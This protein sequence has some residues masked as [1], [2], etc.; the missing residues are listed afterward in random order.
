MILAMIVCD[1]RYNGHVTI[2]PFYNT[3]QIQLAFYYYKNCEQYDS[4]RKSVDANCKTFVEGLRNEGKGADEIKVEEEKYMGTNWRDCFR[5][6]SKEEWI[7]KYN[8][9]IQREVIQQYLAKKPEILQRKIIVFP[10]NFGESHW[11]TTFVFNPGNVLSRDQGSLRTCFFRYCSNV[12]AGDGDR[13]LFDG[14]SWFLNLAHS[15]EMHHSKDADADEGFKLHFPF[16]HELDG[17]LLG[18]PEFP[19]M[20]VRKDAHLVRP[21]QYD[22]QSCGFGIAAGIAIVLNSLLG[23]NAP[24]DNTVEPTLTNE[25][26]IEEKG[27]HS[28]FS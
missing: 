16:G 18:T 27:I 13:Y 25:G 7:Q 11:V 19:A 9:S 5:D 4:V 14:I 8:G 1:G 21:K 2:V 20:K 23:R 10:M 24:D 22:N 3:Q 6:W 12:P 17:I 28:C 26:D 15:C